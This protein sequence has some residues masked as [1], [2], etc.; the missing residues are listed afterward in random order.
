M[1]WQADTFSIN[2]FPVCVDCFV[3]SGELTGNYTVL[4]KNYTTQP[5]AI[6]LTI[7]VQFQ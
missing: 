4:Q 6:S 5:S 1:W 3:E 2:K 7:V